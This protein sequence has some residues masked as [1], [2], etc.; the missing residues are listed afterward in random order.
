MPKFCYAKPVLSSALLTAVV[1]SFGCQ[2]QTSNTTANLVNT[3]ANVANSFANGAN[4]T[5]TNVNSSVSSTI[6]TK[7]PEQYEAKVTLKFEALG[8]AQKTTLPTISANVARSGGDRRMEFVLPGNNEKVVYL[9]KAGTN[10][11]I[12]PNRKQYAELDKEALGFEVRRMLLP[13]QIVQQVKKVQGLQMVGEEQMNGRTVTKYRYEGVANTQSQ[14]GQVG[15]ESLLIVDKETGLPLRSETVAQS[16]TGGNVQ[17]YKGLRFVTEMSDI[18]SV[19]DAA[20][21]AVPTDYAKVDAEQV[22]AQV[23]LIFGMAMQIFGQMMKSGQPPSVVPPANT[24]ASP[25][26]N[27]TPR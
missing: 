5:T 11:V 16:Q 12:L 14:A 26:A 27:M 20:T 7:E 23:N 19:T 8:D 22:K 25:A 1:F 3:N 4:I 24:T 21:F 6:E 17:G 2:P 9:D 10:Y 13:E 15:T 18:K